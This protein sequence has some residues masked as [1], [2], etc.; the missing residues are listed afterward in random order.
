D[1]KQALAQLAGGMA[2]PLEQ[3]R[4]DLLDLLADVEASLDFAHEDI[5]LLDDSDMLKRVAAGLARLRLVQRQLERRSVESAQ[6]RVVLAGLPNAGKSSL[7]NALAGEG[8][9]LVS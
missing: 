8:T 9:A 1:L 4:K 3:L 5:Q 2:Q 7:F 6:F